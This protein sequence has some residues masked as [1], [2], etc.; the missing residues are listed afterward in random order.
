MAKVLAIEKQKTVEQVKQAVTAHILPADKDKLPV[1]PAQA[2]AV[3]PAGRAPRV[4]RAASVEALSERRA[5]SMAKQRIQM[6]LNNRLVLEATD[7]EK[8]M[9]R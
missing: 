8:K 9:G 2:R 5:H 7:N 1:E 4:V 3:K 6:E